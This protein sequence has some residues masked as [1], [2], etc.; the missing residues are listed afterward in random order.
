MCDKW[1]HFECRCLLVASARLETDAFWPFASHKFHQ[2]L[3][4]WTRLHPLCRYFNWCYCFCC[5]C[6]SNRIFNPK[7]TRNTRKM[8]KNVHYSVLLKT[9]SSETNKYGLMSEANTE[10]ETIHGLPRPRYGECPRHHQM[11]RLM[12]NEKS[13]MKLQ[14]VKRCAAFVCAAAAARKFLPS[15]L[16]Q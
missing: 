12:T 2:N 14:S 13:N 3:H 7:F 8:G 11:L 16:L 4:W 6:S 9:K 5:C 1:V 15:L 10:Y